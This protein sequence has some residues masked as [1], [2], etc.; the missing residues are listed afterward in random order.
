MDKQ[1]NINDLSDEGESKFLDDPLERPGVLKK[2]ME[3]G[4]AQ[5]VYW[6]PETY[7]AESNCNFIF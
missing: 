2:A 4:S 5:L 7:P 1:E 3:H 6:I